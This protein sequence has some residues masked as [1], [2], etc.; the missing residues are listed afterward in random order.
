MKIDLRKKADLIKII[1]KSEESIIEIS[2]KEKKGIEKIT[3]SINLITKLNPVNYNFDLEANPGLALPSEKQFGFISQEVQQVIPEFTKIV[4]HPAKLNDEGKEIYPS[5]EVLG[6]NYNGFFAL[7]TKGIQEQQGQ[8][9][10]LSATVNAQQKQLA[11]QKEM[12]NAL[13]NK[14]GS[15][16]GMNEINSVPTG[17]SLEQNIPNPFNNETVIKYT[18]PNTVTNA[19]LVVYDL[20]GKQ[21][22][23]F[24]LTEKGTS[25]ITIT[26]EKLAAGIYIYSVMADGKIIDTKR[27]VVAQK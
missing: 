24:P 1:R 14:A 6:L 10:N 16:T 13:V 9:E 12:I 2:V 15:S 4:I 17:F 22:T 5:R 8:I 19:S 20:S 18:M 26:S 25:S 23:S 3:N 27:M 21:V 11:E 7:L